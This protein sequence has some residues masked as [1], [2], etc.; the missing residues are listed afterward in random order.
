MSRARGRRGLENYGGMARRVVAAYGRAFAVEGDLEELASLAKLNDAVEEAT[1]VAVRAVRAQGAGYSWAEIGEALGLSGPG[2][3]LRYGAKESFKAGP[4]IY[5]LRVPG[6]ERIFYVG[7][8]MNLGLR[9]AAY[10]SSQG[11]TNE[12]T[13]FL[14][15]LDGDVIVEV[16]EEVEHETHLDRREKFWIEKFESEGNEL[17][18]TI[19]VRRKRKAVD[20][21]RCPHTELRE[22]KGRRVPPHRVRCSLTPEHD[23]LCSYRGVEFGKQ[24]PATWTWT[25]YQEATKAS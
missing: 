20:K 2:A 16:L 9:M 7:Q 13:N 1:T 19:H 23:G 8:T 10:H 22:S 21:V 15:K 18:N 5:G 17:M 11:S 6:S 3:R 14:R 24:D 12:V 25:R 4:K